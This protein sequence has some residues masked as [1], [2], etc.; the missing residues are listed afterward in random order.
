[1]HASILELLDQQGIQVTYEPEITREKIMEIIGDFTGIFVRSKTAIDKA[2]L[3]KAISLKFVARAGAGIEKMDIDYLEQKDITWVNAP[4]GNRDS[5]GE[6]TIGLLLSLLHKLHTADQEVRGE[7]WDREGN[8]GLE[9]KGKTVGVF[10]FGF[11]GSAFAEKLA[12]FG[13]KVLAYDKYRSNFG[14]ENVEEV[15]LEQLRAETEILSIHVPLTDETAKLFTIDFFQTFKKLFLLINTARGGLL[16]TET[17]I[18]LLKSGKIVGA[19]L[20]VLENERLHT[21]TPKQKEEFEYLKQSSQVLLTPHVGGWS[22]ESYQ[23]INEV[24]V[25]KLVDKKLL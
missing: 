12:G 18:E 4:E 5:L 10:G 16:A 1:M 11:M 21:L 24:L 2:L 25:R 22:H 9:L 8:R 15:T 3:D 20:D 7:T 19:G 6:H 13:C 23:R 14:T 17:V